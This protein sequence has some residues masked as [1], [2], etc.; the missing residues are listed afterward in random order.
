M[1][2][3][4]RGIADFA[5]GKNI[6]EETFVLSWS[7]GM[8]ADGPGAS[9]RASFTRRTRDPFQRSS[10]SRVFSVFAP[11]LTLIGEEDS[12]RLSPRYMDFHV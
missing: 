5:V 3:K 10:S 11:G 6:S 4:R 9:E 8:T 1:L 2:A 7:F 12:H